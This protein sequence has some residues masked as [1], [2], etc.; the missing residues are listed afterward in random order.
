MDAMGKATTTT[1]RRGVMKYEA[2]K[3][4]QRSYNENDEFAKNIVKKLLRTMD[5]VNEI[6]DKEDYGVDLTVI[7]NNGYHFFFEAEVKTGYAFTGVQDFP[8]DTVSFLGRKKKWEDIGFYYCIVCKETEAV[9]IAHSKDIY[10]EEYRELRN[11]NKRDR[12]GLDAFYR[13]PKENC[14]WYKKE[15]YAN[16]NTETNRR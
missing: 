7:D 14:K 6:D 11:I 13:V 3:F 9:C 2:R 10:K 16:P 4:S 5:W 15:D 12:Q 1:T 8:F